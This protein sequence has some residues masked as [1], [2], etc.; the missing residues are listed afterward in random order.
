[1]YLM[2]LKSL[3]MMKIIAD[4]IIWLIILAKVKNPLLTLIVLVLMVSK[5]I[6]EKTLKIAEFIMFLLKFV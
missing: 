4:I 1:M 6:V 5:I 2:D 3:V